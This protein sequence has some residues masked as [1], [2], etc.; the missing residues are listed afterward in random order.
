MSGFH[1]LYSIGG[2]VGAGGMTLLL[3]NGLTPFWSALCSSVLTMIALA[4]AG[5]RL[6]QARGGKPPPFVTPRGIV[7]LLA[8]LAGVTF[9]VEGAILDWSALLIV[10]SGLVDPARGG[11]GYMVFAA[12][13]TIGR[14]TGDRIITEIGDRRVLSIGG[15]VAI[16]GFILL[17]SVPWPLVA[18]S[19]FLLIGL[20]ASNVVPVLFS[21]AGRQTAMPAGLAVA[22]VTTT[23][24]AGHLAGPA[25]V[26]FVASATNLQTAFWLLVV[27]MALVPFLS[28]VATKRC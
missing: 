18:L 3:S 26:G 16:V 19:G 4:L 24:Y 14:L 11:I 7:L 12:A 27:L 21:L 13:M 22:V 10:S 28:R 25:I 23:G 5:P 17:L 15:S 20:G 2:F 1:A 6:L 9:L 8:S